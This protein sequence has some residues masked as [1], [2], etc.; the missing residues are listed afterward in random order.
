M[1]C[2][3]KNYLTYRLQ[4]AEE[5]LKKAETLTDEAKGYFEDIAVVSIAEIESLLGKKGLVSKVTAL[6]DKSMLYMRLA[7]LQQQLAKIGGKVWLQ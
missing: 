7:R 4:N 5:C 6:S 2:V 3:D 1:T